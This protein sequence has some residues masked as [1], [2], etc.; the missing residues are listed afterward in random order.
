MGC[1][2]SCGTWACSAGAC[3]C[4]SPVA[5]STPSPSATC[6]ASSAC[7][8]GPTASPSRSSSCRRGSGRWWAPLGPFAI[9]ASPNAHGAMPNLALRF[10]ASGGSTVVY[11]SDTEPCAA[12]VELSRGAHTLIHEATY[13]EGDVRRAG[14]HSTAAQAGEVAA[15]AGVRRL[16]LAHLG[17][18]HHDSGGGPRRRGPGPLRWRGG[19]R[20]GVRPVPAMTVFASRDGRGRLL[21]GDARRL[22]GI[23]PGEVGVI[24]TSPPY[25]VRGRGLASAD[26]YARR[27]AVEFAARWRRVLAR[28]GDCWLVL[29]DRHDGREWAG[30]DG[31]V[32]RWMRRTGWTLQAKG[33]WA[34]IRSR[35]RWDNR[36]NYVLRFRK[37]GAHPARPRSTTLAWMLPLPPLARREPL[38]RHPESPDS[39]GA[40]GE[41]QEGRGARSLPGGGD[42]GAGGGAAG[43]AVDRGGAR[44]AHGRAG[45]ATA[46]AASRQDARARIRR[47]S[48][49]VGGLREEAVELS[50]VV[51]G[52]ADAVHDDVVDQPAVA[53]GAQPVV[54]RHLTLAHEHP[55]AH[56]GQLA[57]D[58]LPRE[59][60]LLAPVLLDLPHVGALDEVTEEPG[61]LRPLG[62]VPDVPVTAEGATGHLGP[63]E[64]LVRDVPQGLAPLRRAVG[65][66]QRRVLERLDDALDLGA[67]AVRDG[68]G[69]DVGGPPEGQ[70]HEGNREEHPHGR[71]EQSRT[72]S[73]VPGRRARRATSAANC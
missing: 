21:R 6:F 68:I 52:D 63:V 57:L 26:R 7:S 60:D 34:Q 22:E 29:G 53:L 35:E 18:A 1:P 3:R 11:S 49:R 41:R 9:T 20:G 59:H 70:E 19:D 67:Q 66:L 14:V 46:G 51:G 71:H 64:D 40:R 27:L 13:A 65:D 28:D 44:P 42:G 8:T 58:R 36:I 50:A 62:L 24:V 10:E 72:A 43:A 31:L 4:A 39:P 61:E 15:Q 16:I 73:H 45:G 69:G 54:D 2:R 48:S 32:T 55:R 25:W 33:C 12:V 5:R 17:A 56:D 30:L 23:A 37:A 38:G 47:T